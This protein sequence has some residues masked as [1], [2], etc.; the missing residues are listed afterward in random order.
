MR[1]LVLALLASQALMGRQP[2]TNTIQ[3][4]RIAALLKVISSRDRSLIANE[5]SYP[6]GRD[7]PLQPIQSKADFL[8]RFDEV[9]DASFFRELAGSNPK[10]DWEEM[11]WRGIMFKNGSLWLD[12][13]YKIIAVNH[14]TLLTKRLLASAIQKQKD[15]LPALLRDFD[16]P[17]LEWRTPKYLIRVDLKGDDYRL[18]LLDGKSP[19]RILCVLHHGDFHFEGTMGSFL[20]DWQS[21]G[22]THR[23]YSDASGEEGDGYYLYDSLI[24]RDDWP[25]TPL[26]TQEPSRH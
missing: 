25:D 3:A 9:F 19:T 23:I 12:F 17:I 15:H 22:K 18:A 4:D 14:E 16:Q 11:G 24:S 7:Y 26:E 13:D 1:R 6:L 2:E 5:I 21:E 10:Q 8:K 20:I